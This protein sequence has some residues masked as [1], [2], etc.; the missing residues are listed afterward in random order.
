MGLDAVDESVADALAVIEGAARIYR[1][2]VA[3]DLADDARKL[4]T[5]AALIREVIPDE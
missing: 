5:A 1:E 3:Y 4:E 2:V